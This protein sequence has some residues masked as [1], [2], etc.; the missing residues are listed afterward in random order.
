MR[1]I[2]GGLMVLMFIGACSSDNNGGSGISDDVDSNPEPDTGGTFERGAML[3]NWADNI[4]IP[5]Y[6]D[7]ST[8]LTEL[9]SEYD[10]FKSDS[11]AGNLAALRASW[12]AAYKAWQHVVMFEVGPAETV[13]LRLNIN[14]YP[15]D[16]EVIESNAGNGTYDLKLPSNRVAKGFPALD[17]LIN[18]IG[19]TDEDITAKLSS[20]TGKASYIPYIEAII[21]DMQSLT[22]EVVSE[23][24]QGYRDTF[25]KNDGASA[26]A[27]VDRFVNAYIFYY[28]KFLRAGKM[29]I[30]LGV[31][32]GTAL[33]GN[34]EAYYAE[35][36]AKTLFLEGLNAS[37]DFFNGKHFGSDAK[38]ESLASYLDALN[39][40]KQGE[41]LNE[42]INEQF[43]VARQSVTALNTFREEIENNA[44]PNDMFEAYDEVQRL[45]PLFKVDMV[46]AMSISISYVDADG[47]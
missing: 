13:G 45:V 3:A 42:I 7:F 25:V 22:E 40:L 36:L 6:T 1:R 27:S 16:T 8:K 43:E 18:G 2:L 12:V 10:T 9:S 37:Q 26:T 24:Q 46:S 38:G 14:A 32:T 39:S 11:N 4:I 41:D 30:P 33:P 44:S 17:Y 29:G 35:D 15:T 21:S 47:D 5:A 34:L 23:W 31:F 19:E 28:E 20:D